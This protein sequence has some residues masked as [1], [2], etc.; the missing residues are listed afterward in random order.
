MLHREAAEILAVVAFSVFGV[1]SMRSCSILEPDY[2]AVVIQGERESSEHEAAIQADEL[3]KQAI[4]L[5]NLVREQ[6]R[7]EKQDQGSDDPGE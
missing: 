1:L 4:E 2:P 6:R 3:N 7:K 5:E